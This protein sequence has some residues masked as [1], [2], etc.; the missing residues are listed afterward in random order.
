MESHR[1]KSQTYDKGVIFN[2]GFL[3][4]DWNNMHTI[5]EE[6]IKILKNTP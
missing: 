3:D 2:K 1:L 4:L 6:N 5:V